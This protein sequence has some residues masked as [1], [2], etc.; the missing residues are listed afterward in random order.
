MIVSPLS[1]T[2]AVKGRRYNNEAVQRLL[3]EDQDATFIGQI[4]SESSERQ[5]ADLQVSTVTTP[6]LRPEL[7]DSLTGVKRIMK[8]PKQ[9]AEPVEDLRGKLL[10]TPKQKPEKQEC[11]TGVKRIMKTPRQKAEPLEDI[12]GNLL[13]TPE[14]QECFTGVKRIFRTPKEKAEPLE[15]L[16]GKILKTPE[17]PE[18]G[19]A[20]LG[21]G[22]E[23]L[24]TPAQLQESDA[25]GMKTPKSSPV[26][27]LTGV[28][29]VMKTPVEKGAPVEDVVGVKRLM[30][31]PRQKGEPVEA[32]F[33]LKRLMKS[34]RLRGNAPVEDFEGLQELMEEPLTEPTVQPEAKEVMHSVFIQNTC[35]PKKSEHLSVT[36]LTLINAIASNPWF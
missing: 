2:S 1:V 32:N 11:L 20:S 27:H 19:D 36:E 34:P 21:G 16:Q 13:K 23:L 8:T 25:K 29:R 30:R 35:P 18:A 5:N 22:K 4:Q 17:V 3:D 15:D 10:K 28:K 31:T 12:R 26:V 14:Q 9:K 6:K 33:G 7:P 24:Q